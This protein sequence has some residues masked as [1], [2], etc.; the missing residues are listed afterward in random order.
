MKG[1]V[2]GLIALAGMLAIGCGASEEEV[3]EAVAEAVAAENARGAQAQREA[4]SKLQSNVHVAASAYKARAIQSAENS[5]KES[6]ARARREYQDL[7]DVA[8]ALEA[9]VCST[10]DADG[11]SDQ[12]TTLFS[13]AAARHEE[14][15]RQ[16][17][18]TFDSIVA[19]ADATWPQPQTSEEM[20]IWR[21]VVDAGNRAYFTHTRLSKEMVDRELAARAGFIEAV[22]GISKTIC[23]HVRTAVKAVTAEAESQYN[24]TVARA[25]AKEDAD[26][27]FANDTYS[28][29]VNQ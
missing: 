12:A 24:T 13:G 25:T 28:S 27:G 18:Q 10:V 6:V 16:A 2:I 26:V 21:T 3:A 4:V 15:H 1:I 5:N 11:L 20:T 17:Q 23:N 19:Y 7:I 29:F 22:D 9:N 14:I 8:D